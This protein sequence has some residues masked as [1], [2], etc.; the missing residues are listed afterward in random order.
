MTDE[1]LTL[2]GSCLCGGVRFAATGLRPTV[3]FCHCTQ[4]RKT[5]GHYWAATRAP[6]AGLTFTSDATLTW[7]TSS[8]RARRGFCATCGASLFYQS[9][10]ADHVGIAAGCLDGATGMTP[11]RHIFTADA[12]DYY[13]IPKDAPHVPD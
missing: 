1:T 13:T 2:T 6:R 3:V 5:S 4:C 12:G 8:D 11:L 7:F 10:D 9:N